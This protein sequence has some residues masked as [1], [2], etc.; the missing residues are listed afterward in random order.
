M[1]TN[2]G[3]NKYEVG[4]IAPLGAAYIFVRDKEH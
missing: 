4:G 3:G 2:L 1:V